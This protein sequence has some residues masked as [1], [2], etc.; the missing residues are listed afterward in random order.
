MRE[1]L[2]TLRTAKSLKQQDIATKTGMSLSNYNLIENGARQ[3]N[4]DLSLVVKLS[5]IL[6]VPIEYIVEAEKIWKAQL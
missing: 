3:K 1:W 2:K 4:L 6:D 5:E